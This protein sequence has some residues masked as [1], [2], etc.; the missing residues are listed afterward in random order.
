MIIYHYGSTFEKSRLIEDDDNL[1]KKS[2]NFIFDRKK[3]KRKLKGT[4]FLRNL[5]FHRKK[6][7]NLT[8]T[9]ELH[10]AN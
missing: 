4:Q 5:Y 8:F 2:G 6:K 7:R 3:K 9:L 1:K 10:H